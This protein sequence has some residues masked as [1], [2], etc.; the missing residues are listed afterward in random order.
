MKLPKLRSLEPFM[1][2][3]ATP[4]PMTGMEMEARENL[5]PAPTIQAVMVVPRLAPMMTPMAWVRLSSWAWTKLTTMTV[6][7][8]EDWT[9]QVMKK[10][11]A[12]PAK[13]LVVMELMMARSLSPES[14]RMD[15]LMSFMPKM[16]MPRAPR[17]CRRRESICQKSKFMGDAVQEEPLNGGRLGG[18]AKRRMR[19]GGMAMPNVTIARRKRVCVSIR[20]GLIGGDWERVRAWGGG[21]S[22]AL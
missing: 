11:V 3:R 1:K 5:K 19:A 16:K 6:D 17:T 7:A 15:S 22:A 4:M 10:P 13:R 14:F 9:T 21:F 12:T 8:E 2:L 18:R 20:S